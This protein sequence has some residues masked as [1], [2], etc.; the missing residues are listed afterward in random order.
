LRDPRRALVLHNIK[1]QTS[2]I[3]R[4]SK[5]ATGKLSTRSPF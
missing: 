1:P 5:M 4:E 2:G 3:S